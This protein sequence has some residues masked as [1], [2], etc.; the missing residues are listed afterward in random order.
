MN[1]IKVLCLI[2]QAQHLT[3]W[4]DC[5]IYSDVLWTTKNVHC[6]TSPYYHVSMPCW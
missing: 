5:K 4:G 1:F 6:R 3:N 2:A